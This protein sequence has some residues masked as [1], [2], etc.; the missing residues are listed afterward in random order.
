[1]T[2]PKHHFAP[3]ALGNYSRPN[4]GRWPRLLYFAPLALRVLVRTGAPVS[5]PCS[6]KEMERGEV[7]PRSFTI[8]NLAERIEDVGDRWADLLKTKRSLRLPIERLDK[9]MCGPSFEYRGI[10]TLK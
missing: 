5:A 10:E 4:L 7:A 9:M 1:M 2:I 8:R 6:W 3:S